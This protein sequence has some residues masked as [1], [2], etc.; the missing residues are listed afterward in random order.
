VSDVSDALDPAT[1]VYGLTGIHHERL[2]VPVPFP[3]NIE[4]DDLPR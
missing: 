4:L 1:H 2:T 3:I